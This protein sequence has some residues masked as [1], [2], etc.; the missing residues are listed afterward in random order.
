MARSDV[1]Y[2]S[3]AALARLEIV[4]RHNKRLKNCRVRWARGL[5]TSI[6][7]GRS[8]VDVNMFGRHL[9]ASG[10]GNQAVFKWSCT[11]LIDDYVE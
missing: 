3:A 1:Q 10:E 9:R 8:L 6:M 11:K 5:R 7:Q 4:A 2:Y